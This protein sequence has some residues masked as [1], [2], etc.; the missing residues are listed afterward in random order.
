RPQELSP[1]SLRQQRLGRGRAR[2]A[3]V[4]HHERQ[5]WLEIQ[6][7]FDVLAN[8]RRRE[9]YDRRLAAEQAAAAPPPALLAAGSAAGG[10]VEEQEGAEAA[11]PEPPNL[12]RLSGDAFFAAAAG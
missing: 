6:R 11:E 12:G 2:R 8:P 10:R 3:E 1:A 4:P 5:A 7:A 9:P